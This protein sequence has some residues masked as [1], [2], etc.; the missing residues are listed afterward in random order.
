MHCCT[1]T[2]YPLH[3]RGSHAPHTC[4]RA[5]PQPWALQQP[6]SPRALPALDPVAAE[7]VWQLVAGVLAGGQ[8][9]VRVL[10][11]QPHGQGAEGKAGNGAEGSHRRGPRFLAGMARAWR[12]CYNEAWEWARELVARPSGG[13]GLVAVGLQEGEHGA[14]QKDARHET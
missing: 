3:A 13:W 14:G 6:P 1:R 9:A 12:E 10:G 11:G 4:V 2:A 8:E 5:G 7:G